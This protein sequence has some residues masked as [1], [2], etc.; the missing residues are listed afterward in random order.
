MKIDKNTIRITHR[1]AEFK[2]IMSEGGGAV[3]SNIQTN[4][5]IGRK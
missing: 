5:W 2:R 4:S 3:G 1:N